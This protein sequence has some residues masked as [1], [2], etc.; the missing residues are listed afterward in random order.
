MVIDIIATTTTKLSNNKYYSFQSF[1]TSEWIIF[2]QCAYI[3]SVFSMRT[4]CIPYR[5]YNTHMHFY[6]P[7][8]VIAILICTSIHPIQGLQYS[9]ALLYTPYRDCNTH[10]HFYT[11]RTGISILICTSHGFKLP[12]HV[13]CVCKN[14]LY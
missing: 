2:R 12:L 5:D 7:H 3:I 4:L 14:Y 10:M 9:Y 6:T 13:R 8:T 1:K 11:P